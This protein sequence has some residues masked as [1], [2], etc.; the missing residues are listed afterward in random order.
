MPRP[1]KSRSLDVWMN[2]G[3]VG[4]WRMDARGR[5]TFHYVES[6]LDAPGARPISLS[7]P[8]RPSGSAYAGNAVESFFDNLLPDS[9]EIRRRIQTRFGTASRTPFDLLAEIGRDCVG[10][11]QLLS[12]GQAPE[13]LHRIEG[14]PLDE[15]GVAR[16]LR[17][18]VSTAP[19]GQR[20]DDPLRISIAGAQEKTALLWHE[21]AWHRPLGATP[22][23]HI[24]KLP[25]GRIGATQID[26]SASVENEWLCARIIREFGA[27]IAPCEIS[28]FDDRKA[29]V[30]ERFDRRLAQNGGWWLRLPQEDMCQALGT[31][32]GLKYE[33]DGGP[34]IVEINKLL[35]GSRKSDEDRQAFFRAQL[36]FWML[37]AIDGHAK[38]FSV[39]I[40]AGGRYSLTPLYD[41]VSAYPV[42]GKGA[43]RYAPQKIKMA[44]AA[45]GRNRHYKWAEILPRHW[46]AT[47]EKC[48]LG[49]SIRK[50][51]G[52]LS[53]RAPDVVAT[54]SSSLPEN[55]PDHVST[56][57]F[58][59]L[60]RAADRLGDVD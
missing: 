21:G 12:P 45:E 4:R 17:S 5:Q 49:A 36:M 46:V 55:F 50:E 3:H 40:E 47:A 1:A 58:E 16:E 52:N 33:A 6:W 27:D 48:G 57:V 53:A 42:L 18:A 26:M 29:L 22:S 19:L 32:A 38:N 34:G 14:E 41:V 7:M 51:V 44:M 39:R 2:G 9:A 20:D 10:A 8:L 43:N 28:G 24:F 35:L 37:C 25:L 59:G 15:Q 30:V 60:L 31:P 13:N 23:T 54:V 11:I 56:P